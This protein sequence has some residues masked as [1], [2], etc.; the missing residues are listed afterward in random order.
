MKNCKIL[1]VEDIESEAKLVMKHLK[2]VSGWRF[3]VDHCDRLDAAVQRAT[4]QRY[5]IIL[6]DLNLPDCAGIEVC[7]RMLK[8]APHIPVVVLTNQNSEENW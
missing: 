7:Q 8:A 1:L 3:S 2:R 6:L 4:E 5:D